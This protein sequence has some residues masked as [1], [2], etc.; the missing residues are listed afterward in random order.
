MNVH[1]LFKL[2]LLVL[3]MFL[4]AGSGLAREIQPA[5]SAE[6]ASA[7]ANAAA[8]AR[9]FTSEIDTPGDTGQHTSMVIDHSTGTTYI[10]Y[11][12]ATSKTLR[13]AM[14]RDPGSGGNC[15]P[16]NSWLCQT[17]DSTYGVG[18]Y[19]S[20]DINPTN[21]EIGIAYYDG[22]NGQLMY[23]HGEICPTCVW[24]KDVI[25]K[26]ILFPSDNKGKH[27]SLKFNSFGTPYIAYQ[28]EITSGVDS[29]MVASYVGSGGNCG[30][31]TA[32]DKWKCENHPVR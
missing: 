21:D 23:A 30:Y 15:G 28:F 16:D 27:A 31:G 19:S 18:R 10:S 12:D 17:V 3:I 11:Y 5:E 20:I 6:S 26:P 29:L 14:S 8:N 13:L 9:W 25:D 2:M 1:K 22:T 4:V 7:S 24:S 32:Q